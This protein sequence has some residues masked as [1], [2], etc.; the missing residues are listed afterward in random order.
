M[1]ATAAEFAYNEMGWKTAYVVTDQII[2]YTRSLSEYFLV[3]FDAIGGKILLEDTYTNGDNDFSAQLARL[4]A[5]DEEPDVIFISSYG[6]DTNEFE[7]FTYATGI[8]QYDWRNRY[9]KIYGRRNRGKVTEETQESGIKLEIFPVSHSYPFPKKGFE[10]LGWYN[11]GMYEPYSDFIRMGNDLH[12]IYN[13][14]LAPYNAYPQDWKDSFIPD[15]VANVIPLAGIAHVDYNAG[16]TTAFARIDTFT[17]W[18][19]DMAKLGG[20]KLDDPVTGDGYDFDTVN[21]VL[22]AGFDAGILP[23]AHEGGS[24]TYTNRSLD[25]TRPGYYDNYRSSTVLQ[26]RRVF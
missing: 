22:Q 16:I 14:G 25:N 19:R 5:L 17:D 24:Y 6:V 3:H 21:E 9:N 10:K 8:T 7:H 20:N 1:S 18:Y 4:K 12:A 13:S 23:R 15:D 2:A 11:Q 26:S